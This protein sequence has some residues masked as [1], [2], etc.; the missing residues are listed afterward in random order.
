M[1]FKIQKLFAR[2]DELRAFGDYENAFTCLEEAN[3]L[4]RKKLPFDIET[5]REVFNRIKTAFKRDFLHNIN[6]QF[7]STNVVPVFVLG[8]PR[9]G[10]TLVEQ[11]LASH[12]EVYAAG[13]LTILNEAVNSV[14][15]DFGVPEL[16]VLRDFYLGRLEQLARGKKRYV[17]DKLPLNF[18]WIGFIALALPEAKIINL[19]RDP[20]AVCFSNFC[21]NYTP[22]GNNFA[23]GLEDIAQYYNL[24]TELMDFYDEKFP[25][26]IF[27]MNYELLTEYQ[28]TETRRLLKYVG[29]NFESQCLDFQNNGLEVKTASFHQVKSAMYQG[30]SH[31]WR[32]YEKNLSPM[33]KILG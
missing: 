8:M 18:K 13:E 25:Q 16:T 29:L 10:T 4:R 1:S 6:I 2:A 9:S 23:Y 20:R 31:T 30:S 7:S 15:K 3:M 33:L 19:N 17:I 26:R 28:D 12:S 21:T 27:Q 11:I 22:D 24:Y 32:N 5:D 14:E